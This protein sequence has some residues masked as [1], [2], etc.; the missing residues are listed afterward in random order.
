MN[1]PILLKNIIPEY[2][3]LAYLP[4]IECAIK[5]ASHLNIDS[6]KSGSFN[7]FVG[8]IKKFLFVDS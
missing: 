4:K 6:N 5:I 8:G 2:S 7:S 1:A 3:G